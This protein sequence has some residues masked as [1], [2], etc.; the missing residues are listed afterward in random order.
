MV[1]VSTLNALLY[2]R[3]GFEKELAAEVMDAA[4]EL[5][6]F[7]YS[8]AKPDSGHVLFTPQDPAKLGPLILG[9]RLDQLVFAR[10]LLFCSGLVAG[11]PQADRV[12]PL[13]KAAQALGRAFSEVIIEAPDTSE[14]KDLQTLCR[15]LTSPFADAARR[16]GL[17]G[18]EALL[19]RL[20]VMLLGSSAGYVGFSDP[21]NASPWPMGIP[22]LKFPPG[23]PSRSTLKL[24]EAILTFIPLDAERRSRL[25][26]GM[27]GVDLGASP[28]GWTYQLV[29]RGIHVTAV[30]NGAMAPALMAS[31]LV[32]H[33][34]QDGFGFRPARPVDW[35]VCDMVEQP[36]RVAALVGEWLSA[37]LARE[38]VFNLKL[39][40][41]RRL[42]EV[43]RCRDILREAMRGQAHELRLKQLY[44][45]REEVTGHLRRS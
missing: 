24:A 39:P 40:M 21:K 22:R 19:P 8:K 1:A 27:R 29:D 23:A 11:L 13:L 28:G 5:G 17:F 36:S 43:R 18:T 2:C 41:K 10:Q 33:L 30:D 38:A 32:D 44:H 12:S 6:V 35:L 15:K 14:G 45:D 20:H 31:G 7:G 37:G 3:P 34:R 9:L 4:T 16:A 25:R 26:A 42:D